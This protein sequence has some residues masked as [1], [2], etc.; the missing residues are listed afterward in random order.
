MR[1]VLALLIIALAGC[2]SKPVP[3]PSRY[4][5]FT[6]NTPVLEQRAAA[7]ALLQLAALYPP[8][9]TRFNMQLTARDAFG[10]ALVEGLRAR[11]YALMEFSGQIPVDSS[12]AG[13]SLG[14][15]IDQQTAS[16]LYRVVVVV[17]DSSLARGYLALNDSILPAGAWVRKE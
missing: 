2:A 15:V 8:A 6:A 11:G 7:D 14:Y 10:A 12:S 13:L 16:N 5:N 17:G 4:G 1:T 3:T 9:Q